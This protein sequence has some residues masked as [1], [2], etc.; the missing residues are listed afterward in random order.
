MTETSSSAAEVAD[1]HDA[2][3]AQQLDH[4]GAALVRQR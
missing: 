3:P 2:A 1:A 4:L